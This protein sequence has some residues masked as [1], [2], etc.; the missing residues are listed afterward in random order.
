MRFMINSMG[1]GSKKD[2]VHVQKHGIVIC[3][4]V[5]G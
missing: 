2:H 1:G 3:F 5:K 4:M